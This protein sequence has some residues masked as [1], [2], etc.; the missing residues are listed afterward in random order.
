MSDP[1]GYEVLSQAFVAEGADTVFALLGDANMYWGAMMA[2]KHDV[3]VIHAFSRERSSMTLND[4]ARAADPGRPRLRRVRR[5]VFRLAPP[6]MSLAVACL[7]TDLVAPR[8]PAG[9]RA[10]HVDDR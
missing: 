8:A 3:N 1:N 4:A 6:V 9:L 10:D 2:Q 7:G 5:A